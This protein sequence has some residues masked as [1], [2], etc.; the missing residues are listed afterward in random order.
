MTAW[1]LDTVNRAKSE[2]F[3]QSLQPIRT[4]SGVFLLPEELMRK[5]HER[6]GET[7]NLRSTYGFN[8]LF[9]YDREQLKEIR[10]ISK[11]PLHAEFRLGE[12]Q[13]ALDLPV[14]TEVCLDDTLR[15][16]SSR[17]IFDTCVAKDGSAE[18]TT[19]SDAVRKAPQRKG[20]NDRWII[21]VE[22][23]IYH[24]T[25]YLQREK[26]YLTLQGE[27][28]RTTLISYHLNAHHLGADGQPIGTFKTAS[29]VVDAD[30]FRAENLTIENSAGPTGQALAIRL[31]GDR[32]VFKN[33]RFLGWQDTILSNRGRHY[34]KNCTITGQTDFI[35]GA[36]TC[37]FEDCTIHCLK[38]SYITAASTPE[39]TPYGYVFSRCA[40]TGETPLVQTYLGRPWRDHA[41][42]AFLNCRME[43]IIR[44]EGWHNWGQPI[45]EQTSRYLE[46][47]NSGPGADT[48]MRVNWAKQWT[49]SETDAFAPATILLG[50]DQWNPTLP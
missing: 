4:D 35:F 11:K 42:V 17:H 40:I 8:L 18:Y 21:H 5:P 24:E 33:C 12:H 48:S 7:L 22:P 2:K 37:L 36:G 44:P 46:G 15:E 47:G 13:V 1:A 26:R 50:N 9:A 14:G 32:A 16:R 43:A 6:S 30:D 38:S 34:F 39:D 20:E 10:V 49:P 25:L 31:D 19:V 28:P 41:S 45:R 27:D 3:L 23:G 29:V